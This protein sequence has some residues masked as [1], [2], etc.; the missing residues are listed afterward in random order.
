[1]VR[2]VP[3]TNTVI[4]VGLGLALL[5]GIGYALS[6]TDIASGLR[7]R[8][9][10]S[11]ASSGAGASSVAPTIEETQDMG[12]SPPE[13]NNAQN[14]QTIPTSSS[15]TR[16]SSPSTVLRPIFDSRSPRRDTS[17]P[18]T[19]IPSTSTPATRPSGFRRPSDGNVRRSSSRDSSRAR[20]RGGNVAN[21]SVTPQQR[22]NAQRISNLRSSSSSTR[23]S[24]RNS[25]RSFSRA[26]VERRQNTRRTNSSTGSRARRPRRVL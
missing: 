21:N 7:D 3:V 13:P 2:K 18:T 5:V 24:G 4:G 1:M 16:R 9:N 10:L 8:F 15:S 17:P 11:P 12:S 6:R 22:A 26:S 23:R 14:Q 19:R 20:R 25:G